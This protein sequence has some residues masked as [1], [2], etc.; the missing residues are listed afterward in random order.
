MIFETA[1]K[2]LFY[3]IYFLSWGR[4]LRFIPL[5]L[6]HLGCI[7]KKKFFALEKEKKMDEQ[8]ACPFMWFIKFLMKIAPV[9]KTALDQLFRT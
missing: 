8:I 3:K 2:A 1:F 9:R 5:A 4:L 7:L 6:E